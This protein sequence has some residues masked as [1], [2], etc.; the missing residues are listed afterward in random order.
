LTDGFNFRNTEINAFLGRL[1]LKKL[2]NIIKVRNN[3]LNYFLK[4]LNPE[5][6]YTQFD[7]EGTS[8][9]AFPVITKQDNIKKLK[10]KLTDNGIENRPF[11]AGNLSKQ[12]YLNNINMFRSFPNS[13]VLHFSGMYLGNNQFVTE[14]MI[15]VGLTILNEI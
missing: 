2:N 10:I 4:H 3:N 6:Y 5:K 12:P 9:F 14:K 7:T 13:D 11:I 15:D 1:Q 8:S